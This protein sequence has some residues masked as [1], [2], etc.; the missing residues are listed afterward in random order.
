[1]RLSKEEVYLSNEMIT[2]HSEVTEKVY[3]KNKRN[4]VKLNQIKLVQ[5]IDGNLKE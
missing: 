3:L 4:K 1:M 5:G 2:S